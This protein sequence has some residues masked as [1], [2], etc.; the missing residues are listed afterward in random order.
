MKPVIPS[1]MQYPGY[2][3]NQVVF[4]VGENSTFKI[5]NILQLQD[6]E[7]YYVLLD[8]NGQK[9]FMPAGF[10]KNYGFSAG[11]EIICRID[12]INCTGRIFL[13][14][15]HPIYKEDEIYTFRVIGTSLN[16]SNSTLLVNDIF[17]NCIEVPTC[18]IENSSSYLETMVSCKVKSLIKGMPILELI[19]TTA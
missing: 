18:N 5:H 7:W 10:Y 17:G 9:H 3:T 14:P 16:S 15:R 11:D 2:N 13:E 6:N 1:S 19:S 4:K 8:V 12:K